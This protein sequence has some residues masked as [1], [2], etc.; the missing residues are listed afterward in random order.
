MRSAFA[1]CCAW[2]GRVASKSS[3]LRW[4]KDFVGFGR[5]QGIR[6]SPC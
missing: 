6:G 1:K 2:T 3:G 4:L 5:A